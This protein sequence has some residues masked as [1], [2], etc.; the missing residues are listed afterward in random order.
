[1]LVDPGALADDLCS[2]SCQFGGIWRSVIHS[3]RA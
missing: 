1:V 2:P 3:R